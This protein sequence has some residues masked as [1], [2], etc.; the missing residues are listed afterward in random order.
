M[1][2]AELVGGR[3]DKHLDFRLSLLK[4]V[5]GDPASVVVSTV[6]VVHNNFGKRYLFFVVPFHRWGVQRLIARAISAG[7]M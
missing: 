4:Q 6:C 1:S 5:D 7:R 2:D 3:D